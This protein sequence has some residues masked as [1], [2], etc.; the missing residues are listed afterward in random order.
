MIKIVEKRNCCGC[1]ACVQTCPKSCISFDE[2]N[3]GFRYPRVDLE[4]CIECGLCERV[5]PVSHPY[6]ERK[7]MKIL[8][9]INKNDEVR[10]ASSS[11]GIFPLLAEHVI[12]KCGVVF[13]ARFNDQWQVV[14]DL[15]ETKEDIKAFQGSKY[16]Q[17]QVGN[18]FARCKKFLDEGR[19]VLF[20]GTQCQI[21]GLLHFLHKPYENL[22]T[23]DFI[24]HGVPSPKVW[25]SY[26]DEAVAAG[27]R[28]ITDISFRD[29]R[30][31]WKDY[32]L[33]LEYK[34]GSKTFT[35]TSSFTDNPY[36]K[37]FLANLILRPSC[38]SCPAKDGRSHSDI[39]IADFWGINIIN[40]DMDDDRGTSLVM[41]HSEKGRMAFR[42]EGIL[43][44]ESN[45][46]VVKKYNPAFSSPAVSHPRRKVF[47]EE[48]SREANLHKLIEDCLRPTLK[49]LIK[50]NV[51]LI[52][53]KAKKIL[54]MRPTGGVKMIF[55]IIL[56][57]ISYQIV[58]PL[59]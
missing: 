34:E 3:E 11:G 5:C 14:F 42:L 15:A 9:A 52:L 32:S 25:S 13:G 23:V 45:Y 7:P 1:E 48:F 58:K 12:D 35:M 43:W 41:I 36:S 28:A 54:L 33:T 31:G 57:S 24:C 44:N 2:D 21:A 4:K 6:E 30:K 26:L 16:I 29:K 37:A 27:K 17:A 56:T 8:A 50:K 19:N 49:Q 22:L 38:H 20:S 40:P 47:F 10:M 51:R 59:I 18:S 55:V 46:E 39:T 53:H